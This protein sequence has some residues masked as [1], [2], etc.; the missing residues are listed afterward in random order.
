VATFE[1]KERGHHYQEEGKNVLNLIIS[2]M[3][4]RLS[5]NQDENYPVIDREQLYLK[6]NQLLNGPSNIEVKEDGRLFIKSLNRFYTGSG[7]TEVQII[8][9][10][11]LVLKTFTSLSDGAKF[12]G[13]TQP[14]VKNRL[15]KNQAFLFEGN[16]CYLKRV[17]NDDS[18]F[19][20]SLNPEVK[21]PEVKNP[22]VKS[23]K[24]KSLNLEVKSLNTEIELKNRI[25]ATPQGAGKPVNV[26][27]KVDSSGFK[28]IGSFVSARTAGKFIGIS[29]ST[30]IRYV[31]SGQIYNERYK[32]SSK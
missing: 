25:S 28:L 7:K 23:P 8:S 24:V 30:V 31:Q 15:I 26:Y 22:E 17:I 32:F 5:S 11:G 29:G 16:P 10:K 2:Q 1:L 3:N 19:L 9:D 14:T 18:D 13:L 21:N 4:N 20:V 6:I 27:E 12:L